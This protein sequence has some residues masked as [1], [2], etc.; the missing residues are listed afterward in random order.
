MPDY[1][2]GGFTI[3]ENPEL[4]KL[5]WGLLS[6]SLFCGPNTYL[7]L[8]ILASHIIKQTLQN[9]VEARACNEIWIWD[10]G[11]DMLHSFHT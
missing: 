2:L 5:H 8:A 9:T 10:M 6:A 11:N 4:L 1:M 7:D 3:C